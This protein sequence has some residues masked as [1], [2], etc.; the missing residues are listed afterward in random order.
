MTNKRILNIGSINIDHVYQ[1]EH[2]V[3]P[4]ETLKSSHYSIFAGGKGFNQSIALARAGAKT[5]HAGKVGHNAQWLVD[6]LR[7]DGVDTSHILEDEVQTGHAMIQVIPS[8][9]NAIVLD[10][11]ANHYLTESDIDAALESCAAGDY[12]LV[13]NETNAVDYAIKQAKKQ[14]LKIAFNPAPMTKRVLDYPLDLVDVLVLNQTEAEQLSGKTD[15][16]Q[17]SSF[18]SNRYSEATTVL[19]LGNKGAVCFDQGTMY[20]EQALSVEVV[21]TT[22]AG[23]TFIGFFLAEIIFSGDFSIAL[24]QAVHAA[25]SCVTKQGAAESIPLKTELQF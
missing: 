6:R 15:L 18:I 13:Q 14:N 9:E 5:L 16:S 23:D 8:G 25:A 4:G 11:G 24:K 19:T 3:R 7:Q 20:S 10:S 17:I 2:F 21:D 1:L 22:A 12:L